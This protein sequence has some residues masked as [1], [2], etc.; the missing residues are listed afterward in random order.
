[1]I[2]AIRHTG[3]VVADLARALHFWRDVLGLRVVRRM[4]ESGAHID[5]MLGLKGVCVTTVKLAAPD[6]NLVELL[7][8]HS[9]PDKPNWDGTPCSTG[10]THIALTVEN[11]DETCSR[12]AEAGVTFSALP[13]Y[14]PDGVA[15][16]TYAKG[17]EG[18]LLELVEMLQT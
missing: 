14:S 13:Q 18:A 4:E 9:H 11:L 17:P 16:V 2:T 15:R 10:F 5:A 3:L 7:H 1:M 8:F 12:L 6:N